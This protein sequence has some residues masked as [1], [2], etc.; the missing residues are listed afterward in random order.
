MK[1]ITVICGVDHDPEP[2]IYTVEI[3]DDLIDGTSSETNILGIYKEEAIRAAV[4]EQRALDLCEDAAAT[5]DET[6][7]LHFAF[8]GDI[9]TII[10]W[11]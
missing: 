2:L 10:D 7:T 6:L 4:H 5:L 9:S 1:T 3:P 11:R 8:D